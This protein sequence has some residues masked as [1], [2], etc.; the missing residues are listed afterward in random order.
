MTCLSIIFAGLMAGTITAI[1]QD[2]AVPSARQRLL[3]FRSPTSS[4]AVTGPYER[5]LRRQMQ[6]RD[7]LDSDLVHSPEFNQV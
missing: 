2:N 7:T 5:Y 6:K 3:P 1:A 4:E